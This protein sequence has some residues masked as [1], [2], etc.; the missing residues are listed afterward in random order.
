MCAGMPHWTTC[1]L[2]LFYVFFVS[3]LAKDPAPSFKP[4]DCIDRPCSGE[5]V[6]IRVKYY[7]DDDLWNEM[8][9][10][11]PKPDIVM[12]INLRNITD[13]INEHLKNLDNDGYEL[14]F[15]KGNMQKLGGS[16]VKLGKF[17]T[18]RLNG[19]VRK[20]ADKNNIFS[21]TFLFQEA[22]QKLPKTEK[23]DLRI[24]VVPERGG[25]PTLATSEENCFCNSDWKFGCI[26][27]FSIRYKSNWLYHKNIFAH[28]IG[29]TLGMDLHDD[30]FYSNNPG[31][32]L[33][34]WSSV[35]FSA[36]VWSTEAKRRIN[37]HRKN[38]VQRSLL[39]L[40]KSCSSMLQDVN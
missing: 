26:G 11:G 1:L 4:P 39:Q 18:D 28:E 36:N 12:K 35:G 10:K 27:V 37:N 29:H 15:E 8:V 38:H 19:D 9:N 25:N 16:D 21:H 32:K 17:Y 22:V 3:C 31:D 20:K 24:L 7:I 30:I 5:P 14:L 13:K 6:R 23:I 40:N 33:L 34:M 2:L